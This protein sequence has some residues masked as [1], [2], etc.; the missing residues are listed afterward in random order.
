LWNGKSKVVEDGVTYLT[1]AY[2]SYWLSYKTG[3]KE[4][5]IPYWFPDDKNKSTANKSDEN[6]PHYMRLA[7]SV[8][9]LTSDETHRNL[10]CFEIEHI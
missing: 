10:F 4:Y 2:F 6:K 8:V 3:S 7:S 1:P 9:T 5:L